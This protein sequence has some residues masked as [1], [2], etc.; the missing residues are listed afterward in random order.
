MIANQLQLR[1]AHAC[2]QLCVLSIGRLAPL[3]VDISIGQIAP[4]NSLLRTN[5]KIFMD[6]VERIRRLYV[7]QHSLPTMERHMYEECFALFTA[8]EHLISVLTPNDTLE[9]PRPAV[10]QPVAQLF[11]VDIAHHPSAA[12][13]AQVRHQAPE[14]LNR[15]ISAD[16]DLPT[17]FRECQQ[18][19]FGQILCRLRRARYTLSPPT[20]TDMHYRK[21]LERGD[22]SLRDDGLIVYKGM[23]ILVPEELQASLVQYLHVDGTV[24]GNV[25]KT[26]AYAVRSFY[27]YKMRRDIQRFIAGCF[28]SSHSSTGRSS[29]S[30]TKP[31]TH[32]VSRL[33]STV[34]AA[35]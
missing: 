14:D 2:Q 10:Q 9:A 3:R 30:P 13:P 6:Q 29:Y 16:T 12:P 23:R 17:L 5:P 18:R 11:P 24:H 35:P 32:I 21:D 15:L 22:L 27:W 7:L 31:L 1:Y 20:I 19:A 26:V 33:R 8:H 34:A 28:C 25:H 4:N